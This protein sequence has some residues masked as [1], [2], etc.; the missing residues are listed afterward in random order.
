[1]MRAR[2]THA[3][4]VNLTAVVFWPDRTIRIP[5]LLIRAKRGHTS[6]LSME[7]QWRQRINAELC[8][9]WVDGTH[10]SLMY[11]PQVYTVGSIAGGLDREDPCVV[12]PTLSGSRRSPDGEPTLTVAPD[13]TRSG[14]GSRTVSRPERRAQRSRSRC[15]RFRRSSSRSSTCRYAGRHR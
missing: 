6:E 1:M 14:L 12:A 3:Y 4:N 10:S 11:E 2:K 15:L 7:D 9:E 5:T 8:V 13:T